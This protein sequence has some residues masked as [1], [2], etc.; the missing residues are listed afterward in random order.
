M[1]VPGYHAA[2]STEAMLDLVSQTRLA[3]MIVV[4]DGEAVIDH[5]PFVLNRERGE[6]G[7]LEA[8]V[9]RA[10][11]VAAHLARGAAVT[12]LF[13]GPAHYLSPAWY[14][15]KAQTGAVVPTWNYTVVHARGLASVVDS[16][17]SLLPMLE[18]LTA[19]NE[20]PLHGEGHWTVADAPAGYITPMLDAIVGFE[21]EITELQGRWKLAQDEALQD[22]H[23]AVAGLR[24]TGCPRA[25]AMSELI[26]ST[27]T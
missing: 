5:L 9:A 7:T 13:Q 4:A 20:W 1:Y 22:R 14:P 18:R 3:T 15:T 16:G 6:F 26:E 10:N 25:R 24:S 12:V 2:P 11:P 21:I 23:G 17:T 27:L 8:H 19:A